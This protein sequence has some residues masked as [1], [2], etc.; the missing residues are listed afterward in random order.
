MQ[1]DHLS[2]NKF[3]TIERKIKS[4]PRDVQFTIYN[5]HSKTSKKT[6][7]SVPIS[8]NW[9]KNRKWQSSR[10]IFNML[11]ILRREKKPKHG[12][13]RGRTLNQVE[14]G[15]K[16]LPLPEGLYSVVSGERGHFLQWCSHHSWK[17]SLIHAPGDNLNETHKNILNRKKWNGC[18]RRG[19]RERK[20]ISGSGRELG[21]RGVNIIKTN[22]KYIWKYHKE[23]WIQWIYS[24]EEN[25]IPVWY[26]VM[27]LCVH[28]NQVKFYVYT[29]KT[30]HGCSW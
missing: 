7:N 19:S 29:K 9:H 21:N 11:H 23:T 6:E 20:E 14:G 8:R 22:Y 15:R 27:L 28:K 1:L 17:R 25:V 5:A 10:R 26:I 16:A 24:K 2:E 3:N 30:A 13:K 12:K 4:D 18:R